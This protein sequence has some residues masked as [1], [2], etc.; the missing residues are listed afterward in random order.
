MANGFADNVEVELNRLAEQIK[1]LRETAEKE[2]KS[3]SEGWYDD[4]MNFSDLADSAL[5]DRDGTGDYSKL[6]MGGFNYQSAFSMAFTRPSDTATAYIMEAQRRMIVA[7]SR[8]FCRLNPYWLAIKNARIAYNVGT[9][10][11]YSIVARQHGESVEEGLDKK[12]M[13]EITDFIRANKYRKRQGEKVTRGDRDGE[14]FLRLYDDNPDGILRVRFVEP[15]AIQ[16]PPGMGPQDSVWF[17]IQF[18]EYNYEEAIGYYIRPVTADGRMLDAGEIDQWKTMVPAEEIQHGKYN[19]DISSPR[20]VPTTYALRGPLSQASATAGSMGKQV[21]IRTRIAAIWTQV[22]GTASQIQ[23]LLLGNRAGQVQA[24]GG[25]VLNAFQYPPG[26]IVNTNDQRKLE[27]PAPHLETDKIVT[28]VKTDLQAAAAALGFADFVLSADSKVSFAGALVKEGPM[29]KAVGCTQQDLIDDDI[30]ILER[31]L[32]HAAKKGR[33]PKDVLEKVAINVQAP[34]AI[35]RTRIQDAQADEIYLRCG[36]LS[37]QSMAERGGFDWAVENPR[38][39]DDPPPP[40][41]AA[42]AGA[43]NAEKLAKA[44]IPDPNA[45]GGGFDNK[46]SNQAPLNA[47]PTGRGV[48]PGKEPGPSQNPQKTGEELEEHSSDERS[49]E[50]PTGEDMRMA[51]ILLPQSWHEAIKQQIL[52][53]PASANVP[54]DSAVTTYEPGVKGSRLGVVNGEEVWA[55]DMRAL[56]VKHDIPDLVVAGNSEKWPSI[57]KDR[58]VVDW[59]FEPRDRACD[60]Y[61]EIIEEALMSLGGWGYARAH[62]VANYFEMEWLLTLRPELA[63]LRQ[64]G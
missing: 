36:A 50:K 8:A 45:G 44:P 37:R 51:N 56:S 49:K 23:G 16:D 42:K 33:L 31:A 38:I 12:C 1:G 58:I 10:H 60:L 7:A 13:K 43:E 57:P 5:W 22:N 53:L 19:V 2:L 59:S 25:R 62:R 30:Y 3:L 48:P 40:Y 26:S 55:V 27:F 11:T 20:G 29:D 34:N 64:N 28:S 15:I 46:R 61:H 17:G 41:A 24:A 32:V 14:W 54:R 9:G 47:K 4:Y 52:A 6:W 35:E 21:D 18:D 63:T 39:E